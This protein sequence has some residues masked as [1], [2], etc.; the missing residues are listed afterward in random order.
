MFYK[1]YQIKMNVL[2]EVYVV[3]LNIFADL[4]KYG[5]YI[6]DQINFLLSK[7]LVCKVDDNSYIFEF[8]DEADMFYYLMAFSCYIK[9][10]EEEDFIERKE[11]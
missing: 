7:Y 5:K 8:I 11:V 3:E 10:I 9:K 2:N 1:L 6:S 4:M